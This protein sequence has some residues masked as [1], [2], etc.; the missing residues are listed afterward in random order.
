M[1]VTL[2]TLFTLAHIFVSVKTQM[3]LLI[4]ED[5]ARMRNM[6]KDIFRSLFEHIYEC[7]DGTKA[8]QAY[9][10]NK[11]NWVFMDVKMKEKD[12]I[13]A[14]REITRSFPDAKIL[15]LT[16]FDDEELRKAAAQSGA[17]DYVLK[18]N[19]EVIFDIIYK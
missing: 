13:T 11:P 5:N 6:L 10:T 16:D 4:V 15:I 18:E 3:K 1:C 12:G 9:K 7:E 17:I 19:L 14:T 2:L 8:L